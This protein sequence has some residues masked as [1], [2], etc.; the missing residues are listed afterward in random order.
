M[1]IA[2][3]LKEKE[4]QIVQTKLSKLQIT[5]LNNRIL[6]CVIFSHVHMLQ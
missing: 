6:L 2:G 3:T 1:I 4:Q 5:Q